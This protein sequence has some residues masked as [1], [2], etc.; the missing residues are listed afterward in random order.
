MTSSSTGQALPQAAKMPLLFVSR[1]AFPIAASTLLWRLN[2]RYQLLR[3][4]G[5]VPMMSLRKSLPSVATRVNRSLYSSVC[6]ARPAPQSCTMVVSSSPMASIRR[7]PGRRSGR[8]RKSLYFRFLSFCWPAGR[9]K[10]VLG[11]GCEA[12]QTEFS[13][14]SQSNLRK[15]AGTGRC[16]P[17]SLQHLWRL[18]KSTSARSSPEFR[19]SRSVARAASSSGVRFWAVRLSSTSLSH[20]GSA[21]CWRCFLPLTVGSG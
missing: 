21:F 18:V 2:A 14:A 5:R 19:A 6:L 8:F 10:T 9:M 15:N 20:S 11:F 4:I 12:F 1:L 16:G 17:G 13:M 3:P 7:C